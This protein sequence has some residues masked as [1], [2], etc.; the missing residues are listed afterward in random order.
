MTEARSEESM[1]SHKSRSSVYI[2]RLDLPL[3]ELIL[4]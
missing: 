2:K 1:E 3:V 4:H